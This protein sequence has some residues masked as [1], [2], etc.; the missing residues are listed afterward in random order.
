MRVI[1]KAVGFNNLRLQRKCC[2]NKRSLN[3]TATEAFHYFKFKISFQMVQQIYSIV[4]TRQ[5][6]EKISSQKQF[7]L[8]LF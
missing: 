1:G 5:Q 8:L 7:L 3:K 2:L 4:F 6:L